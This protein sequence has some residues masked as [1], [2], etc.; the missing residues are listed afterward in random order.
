MTSEAGEDSTMCCGK[1]EKANA[2]H[3]TLVLPWI[4]TTFFTWHRKIQFSK[5]CLLRKYDLSVLKSRAKRYAPS[6]SKAPQDPGAGSPPKRW[7]ILSLR[8]IYT[9]SW[10]N[11]GC[12][13]PTSSRGIL[14]LLMK[15][16]T[17][18]R[19]MDNYFPFLWCFSQKLWFSA[20]L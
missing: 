4:L 9:N 19:K 5:L 12:L 16:I 8:T 17:I 2:L 14:M 20:T 11:L 3:S 10:H 13:G 7:A 18:L 6:S 1:R 15:E